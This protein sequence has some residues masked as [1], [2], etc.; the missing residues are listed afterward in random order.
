MK[1]DTPSPG[2]SDFPSQILESTLL[3][4]TSLSLFVAS[5]LILLM[6][7]APVPLI[8]QKPLYIFLYNN[9]SSYRPTYVYLSPS[10]FRHL[11]VCDFAFSS[12]L[13]LGTPPHSDPTYQY[14]LYLSLSIS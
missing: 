13:S 5:F 10:L 11:L 7:V 4:Q 14:A 3:L 8:V 6:V 9:L 2:N 1:N 12:L